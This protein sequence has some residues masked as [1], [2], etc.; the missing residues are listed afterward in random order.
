[1]VIKN[2]SFAVEQGAI[3][4]FI[5]PNGAG[6][7]TLLKVLIGM[8]SAK[9]TSVTLD[10][11]ALSTRNPEMNVRKGMSFVPQGN[12]VFTE[13]SVK[14]N[15]EVGGYLL[16]GKEEVGSRIEEMLLIFPDLKERLKDNSGVLSGGEK[17]Q[18]ALARA[19]MLKP[20]VLM[21]D[22]PSLGLS[23]KLVTK[24]FDILLQINKELG[25]T[26]LVVEQKVHEVLRIAAWVYALRM[27]EIVFSGTPA[28]VQQGETMKKIF[29]V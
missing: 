22:E 15:L 16:S 24:A 13:L 20:K 8:L 9:D 25:T 14:E 27:G 19:L 7:S 1:M 6:K 10:G 11:T 12:R 5:G 26:I 18:L 3:I 23:P 4:A 29:L 28:E 21:L 17:Q 2:I